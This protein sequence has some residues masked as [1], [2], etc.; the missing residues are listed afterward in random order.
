VP[1]TKRQ[2]PLTPYCPLTHAS[3]DLQKNAFLRFIHKD[4]LL[5]IYF[6]KRNS[7]KALTQQAQTAI[8]FD[9]SRN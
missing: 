3:L 5:G 1:L 6:Y 9:I 4:S 7:L 2:Y 8:E